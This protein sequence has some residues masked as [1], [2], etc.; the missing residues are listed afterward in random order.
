MTI[1]V[2]AVGVHQAPAAQKAH[3]MGRQAAVVAIDSISQASRRTLSPVM[4]FSSTDR[5][6]ADTLACTAW[7]YDL[8]GA[9][10]T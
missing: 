2:D 5:T 4:A 3:S 9:S 8:F 10:S 6:R 7:G 1:Q